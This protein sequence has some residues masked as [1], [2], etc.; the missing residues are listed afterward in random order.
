MSKCQ[1]AVIDTGIANILN[2]CRALEYIGYSAQVVSKWDKVQADIMVLPGVGSFKEAMVSLKDNGLV[3]VVDDFASTGKG[4]LGICLGMQL[5]L[6]YGFEGGQTKGL[7][8]IP[9]N[10]EIIPK[11]ELGP[12]TPLPNIGWRSV[13]NV[14]EIGDKLNVQSVEDF[15]HYFVHSYYANPSNKNHVVSYSVYS[16]FS[17]PAVIQKDNVIGV[18]FHPEK[19]GLSGVRYM[20][21]TLKYLKKVC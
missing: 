17:F 1:V 10:V 5:F 20:S 11:H 21:S 13:Q 9:G 8:L 7:G 18:Q 16:G 4:L 2:V 12:K 6:D 15:D 19:S 3:E 14:E